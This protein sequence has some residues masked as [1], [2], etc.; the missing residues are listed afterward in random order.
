[1]SSPRSVYSMATSQILNKEVSQ[2]VETLFES[3]SIAGIKEVSPWC[4]Q[5]PLN[6]ALVLC[7]QYIQI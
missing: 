1:M 3:Q 2:A 4:I 5:P 6:A 7:V